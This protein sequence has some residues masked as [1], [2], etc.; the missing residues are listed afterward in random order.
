MS[1]PERPPEY[2]MIDM[3]Y[4]IDKPESLRPDQVKVGQHYIFRYKDPLANTSSNKVRVD[5][6]ATVMTESTDETGL[7]KYVRFRSYNDNYTW[8]TESGYF[9][10]DASEE[11]RKIVFY[12]GVELGYFM[13]MPLSDSERLLKISEAAGMVVSLEEYLATVPQRRDYRVLEEIGGKP[14]R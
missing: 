11:D 14:S 13:D 4:E 9:K 10:L 6:Y 7:E 1:L 2:E 3:Q 8:C 12:G 5:Y